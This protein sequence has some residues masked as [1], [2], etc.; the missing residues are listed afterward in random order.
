MWQRGF[1][2]TKRHA[3]IHANICDCLTLADS[4][5]LS[6]LKN[7][8]TLWGQAA[9]KTCIGKARLLSD[10][11]SCWLWLGIKRLT[12]CMPQIF[13]QN[14][15]TSDKESK[16]DIIPDIQVWPAGSKRQGRGNT[17]KLS[18]HVEWRH[19]DPSS[20]RS[21]L[22][23]E[24]LCYWYLPHHWHGGPMHWCIDHFSKISTGFLVLNV[25]KV[26]SF[27]MELFKKKNT[28]SR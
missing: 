9:Q 14:G 28:T 7:K 12:T 13:L 25:I 3:H 2:L 20:F 16:T 24:S 23:L 10:V 4:A 21:V 18:S 19:F 27:L 1:R 22:E 5:L 11:F 17:L 8:L 15:P 6:N 26:G